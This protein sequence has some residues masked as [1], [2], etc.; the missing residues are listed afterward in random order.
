LVGAEDRRVHQLDEL[1]RE[2]PDASGRFK[3]SAI[4]P[5]IHKKVTAGPEI[6]A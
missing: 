4:P 6:R 1:F 2:K 5:D 3:I